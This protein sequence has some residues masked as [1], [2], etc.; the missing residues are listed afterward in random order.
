MTKLINIFLL[1][2]LLAQSISAKKEQILFDLKFGFVKGGEAK[3]II[4]DTT[5]NGNPAI[6]FYLSG[7]TTG[8]TDMVYDI[9]DIYETI[10]DANTGL[11]LKNIRNIKEQNY[12]WYNETYFYHDVDSVYSNKT[13]WIAVPDNITDFL[14][15]LFFYTK[16]FLTKET[17]PGATVR[18]PSYHAG[19]VS[20]ITIKYLGDKMIKTALGNINTS[21]LNSVVDK[22]KVL[23]SSDGIR[24]FIS[25]DKKIPVAFE[26]DLKV[27]GLKAVLKSYKIDN[28]EQVT[29]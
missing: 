12:R 18:L 3:I 15:V 10:V 28:I 17:K 24:F 26:F 25:K 2:F 6:Y 22:G 4:T 20:S 1:F 19:K 14:S 16:N 13:G 7:R 23:D 8:I 9:N 11:P 21:L 29:R 27:G 5:F